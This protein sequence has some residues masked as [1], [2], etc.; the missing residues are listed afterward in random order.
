MVLDGLFFPQE[1]ETQSLGQ[2]VV[3]EI[4]FCS[5]IRLSL[6]DGVVHMR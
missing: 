4:R 1:L 3:V 5:A 2:T 6:V